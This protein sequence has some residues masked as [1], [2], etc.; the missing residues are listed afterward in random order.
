MA[1]SKPIA[2]R[3]VDAAVSKGAAKK[4]GAEEAAGA[5]AGQ[6]GQEGFLP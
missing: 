1:A 4:V 5:V 6:G 3:L 2:R